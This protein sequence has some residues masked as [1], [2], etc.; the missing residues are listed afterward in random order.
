MSQIECTDEDN[1][2]AALDRPDRVSVVSLLLTGRQLRKMVTV[3]QQPFPSLRHLF[4]EAY[5][6]NE[7]DVPALPSEFLGRSAPHLQT[8]ELDG[9]PFPSLPALL[10]T[11][12]DLVTLH[13]VNI[14]QTGY[15]P[16]EAMVAA[17]ATLG[18]LEDLRFAFLSPASCP[19]QIRLLPIA[20]SVLPAL[21]SF[22][23]R[24]VRGYLEDFMARIDAPRL[25]T[26]WIYYFDQLVDF[27][28][29]QLCRFIDNSEVNRPSHCSVHF[30]HSL[31]SFGAGP[32]IV[33]FGAGPTTHTRESKFYDVFPRHIV[34]RILCEGMDLQV[35]HLAQTL[36]QI[37]V[38]LSN[39]VHFVIGYNSI[40]PEP[41]GMDNIEW[42]QL[43]RPFSSVRTLF[44]SRDF[45]GHVSRSLDNITA[46]M[47]T[48]VLPA[49]KM[50]CLEGEPPSSDHK[51]IA[52]RSE[53]GR[54]V[55]V[56]NTQ[57]EFQEGLKM[58][59]GDLY[60]GDL[61][62]VSYILE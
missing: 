43:L 19:D 25:H 34:V 51:F 3:M 41:E 31:I 2:I 49:L 11:S 38:I 5:K 26:I 62:T 48:E 27:E 52:T 58:Y 16:P 14:P 6:S 33:S 21:T 53:S 40:S 28:V 39:V 13:L 55:L 18:R 23:F 20:R 60:R 12:A 32:T 9:I 37:S 42:L 7:L 15:I 50:L 35:S 17:L 10:L 8:I 4:L 29:P 54:P 57:R 22:E 36:D 44:V 1:I 45:A 46:V 30:Q 59:L 56:V 61:E 47:A 24:G